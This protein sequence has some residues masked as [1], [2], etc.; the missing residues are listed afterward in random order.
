MGEPNLRADLDLTISPTILRFST[1]SGFP[2]PADEYHP[3]RDD[4]D[5]GPL[6]V[7]LVTRHI[8][9]CRVAPSLTKGR[10]IEAVTITAEAL[11]WL[12]CTTARIAVCGLNPH[13]GDGGAIGSEEQDVIAPVI[14]VVRRRGIRA[15]GSVAPDAVF[16][17]AMRGENDA[18]VCMYHDQGLGP[19]KMLAFDTDVNV[20]VGLPIVRTSPA[21]GTAF[22]IAGRGEADPSSMTEAIKLAYELTRRRNPWIRK[23]EYS[24]ICVRCEESISP[25]LITGY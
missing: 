1:I 23:Y 14:R 5:G 3:L 9:L 20:T 2:G 22:D 25:L 17:K 10:I 21:H 4:V 8:P 18:V 7:V 11:P 13:T 16:Y 24:V 6:R 19:L 15:N 12:G